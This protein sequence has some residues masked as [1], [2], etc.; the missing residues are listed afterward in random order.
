MRIKTKVTEIS[1]EDLKNRVKNK[2][3]NYKILKIKKRSF[4]IKKNNTTG[5]TIIVGK[6]A[7]YVIG[8]FPTQ[9]GQIISYTLFF[10]FGVVLYSI[11]F[12]SFFN[13]Q[14]KKLEN[15]VGAY[16]QSEVKT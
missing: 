9:I 12:Y 15:E 5:C 14:L 1:V 13:K 6:Q 10:I 2:F 3:D 8:N 4:V 7:I 16:I 11:I